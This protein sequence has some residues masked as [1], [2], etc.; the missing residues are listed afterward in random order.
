MSLIES[1]LK[2][3]VLKDALITE[4]VKLSEAAFKIRLKNETIGKINF[5]PGSF[6][7]MGLGIGKDELSLKDKMRSYS[8]WDI[9]KD[10]S[11]M[12]VAIATHSNGIGSQWIKE[13]NVGKKIYFKTKKGNFLAD[14]SADSYMMV[15]DLSALSHLYM[16]RRNIGKDK[17]VESILYSQNKQD[18]FPDVDGTLPFDFYELPE[19]PSDEII[20]LLREKVAT[21]KGKR[22]AYIAGDSRV[23]VAL[24]RFF[25]QELH[26]E[27]KQIKTKPFW[28][29]DKKGLE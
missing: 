6:L 7:R 9:N 1:I 27:T 5:I 3:V 24:N 14:D 22:M 28:N 29:P 16:I 21:F 4:K 20:A 2:S 19:N 12:D 26:W 23:C 10:K 11:Y 15:G 25:R 8:I 18:L 17:Q 13:C